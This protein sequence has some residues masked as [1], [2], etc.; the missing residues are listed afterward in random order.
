[1]RGGD[2]ATCGTFT[3]NISI[4]PRFCDSG[5]GDYTIAL[6]SPCAPANN[7]CGVLMGVRPVGCGPVPVMFSAVQATARPQFVEITWKVSADEPVDGFDIFRESASASQQVLINTGGRVAPNARSFHDEK[8]Q[9]ST[10]YTYRVV[11]VKPDGSELSS[12]AAT[13]TTPAGQLAL[14]QNY[15]NPFNPSTSIRYTLPNDTRVDIAVYDT[16]G[17]LVKRLVSGVQTAGPHDML[18]NGRD[19]AGKPASSGVYFVKL[20]SGKQTLTRKMLL[21]K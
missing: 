18:W 9:W 13:V 16:R 17:K 7:S 3:D 8:F 20:T 6:D 11:A 1:M 21:L 15:P 5:N 4:D 2:T 10:T 12:R 19:Q 14:E